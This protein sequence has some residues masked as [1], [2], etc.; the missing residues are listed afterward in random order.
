MFSSV[1]WKTCIKYKTL[2]M[3]IA[4]CNLTFEISGGAANAV[5]A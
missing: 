2:A 4:A 1:G 5:V 3:E